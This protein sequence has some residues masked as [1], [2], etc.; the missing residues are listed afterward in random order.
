MLRLADR[1]GVRAVATNPVRYL[2]PGDAFV[3][4]VLECMRRIVPLAETNVSSRNAEGWLKPA[5]E[6]RALFAERPDL[7]EREDM[8]SMLMQAEFEDGS[9]MEDQELRDQ[10]R[11]AWEQRRGADPDDVIADRVRHE[12]SHS[13]RTWH[14]PQPAVEVV[15]G[16]AVLTGSAPHETGKQEIER[17]AAAV[18]GVADVDNRLVVSGSGDGR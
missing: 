6:M 18:D 17:V 13:P 14:L 1:V 5:A 16:R 2:E 15:G 11:R 8:L 3:A 9:R 4:D 12:L 10:L 7:A